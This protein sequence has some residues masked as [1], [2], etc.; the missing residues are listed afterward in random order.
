MYEPVGVQLGQTRGRP[1]VVLGGGERVGRGGIAFKGEDK[2]IGR[3]GVEGWVQLVQER[4]R[5]GGSNLCDEGNGE[6]A[7]Q[8]G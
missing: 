7:A 1:A 6:I 3:E 2:R 5:E 4:E 8:I